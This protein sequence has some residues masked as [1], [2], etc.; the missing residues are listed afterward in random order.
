MLETCEEKNEA[1]VVPKI[2]YYDTHKLWMAGGH[3]D[4]WRALGVH[5]GY[6]KEDAPQYNIAK[7]ITYAPTC[8]MLV[9]KEVFDKIGIMDDKYF[10][11][12]DDTDFVFRAIKA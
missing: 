11:Y 3:M 6:N 5:E 8:F 12:Y 2:F 10:A 9:K 4:N 1:L 7:Q